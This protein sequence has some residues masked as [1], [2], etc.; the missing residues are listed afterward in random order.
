MQLVGVGLEHTWLMVNQKM[1]VSGTI[2]YTTYIYIYITALARA[3][4]AFLG[5]GE[6]PTLEHGQGEALTML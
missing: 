1:W 6:A 2:F 3:T 4:G 5:R